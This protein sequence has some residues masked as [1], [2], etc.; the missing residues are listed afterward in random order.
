MKKI[1]LKSIIWLLIAFSGSLAIVLL[2]GI[3]DLKQ[4]NSDSFLFGGFI[5]IMATY[6]P[7]VLYDEE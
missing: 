2:S 6:I 3:T 4:V 1:I 7:K 5:G